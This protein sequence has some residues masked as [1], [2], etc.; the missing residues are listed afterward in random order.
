MSCSPNTKYPV[1]I[2]SRG[3]S[4]LVSGLVITAIIGAWFVLSDFF[5]LTLCLLAVIYGLGIAFRLLLVERYE[6]KI[7]DEWLIEYDSSGQEKERL[8]LS[9]PFEAECLFKGYFNALYQ[10]TQG[11]TRVRFSARTRGA[12]YVVK[13][14]LQLQWPP[15]GQYMLP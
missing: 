12:P 7:Q 5:F 8:N 15:I 9:K 3:W 11:E 6:L 10:L 4:S 13:D 1:T 2:K 14:I